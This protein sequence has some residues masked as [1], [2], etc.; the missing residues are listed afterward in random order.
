MLLPWIF[1]KTSSRDGRAASRFEDTRNV[2]GERLSSAVQN[3]VHTNDEKVEKERACYVVGT[4]RIGK[5]CNTSIR[6]RPLHREFE[7]G[8]IWFFGTHKSLVESETLR[9]FSDGRVCLYLCRVSARFLCEL[10]LLPVMVGWLVRWTPCCVRCASLD[11]NKLPSL[12]DRNLCCRGSMPSYLA[13]AIK[14]DQ[15]IVL[16]CIVV[17]STVCIHYESNGHV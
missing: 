15:I 11:I 6:H 17:S 2:L 14:V 3:T 10:G 9:F 4:A 12:K 13:R 8:P 16:R 1:S 5:N 7:G